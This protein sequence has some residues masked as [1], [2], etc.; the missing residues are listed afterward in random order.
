MYSNAGGT[1]WTYID[2]GVI[3]TFERDGDLYVSLS[4]RSVNVG[5][6]GTGWIGHWEINTLTN[7]VWRAGLG[8]G[9]I[10]QLAC[11]LLGS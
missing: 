2:T 6:A 11:G 8:V 9:D 10:D 7:E 3:R 5:P 4:G 1:T